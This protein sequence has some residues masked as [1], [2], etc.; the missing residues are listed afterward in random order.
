VFSLDPA[1]PDVESVLMR[2]GHG[3]VKFLCRPDAMP[4]LRTV[5]AISE[6]MPEIGRQFY[7]TGPAKGAATLRG[8]LECQ[9]AA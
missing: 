7:A 5:I 1:D 2:L 6:R 4:P 8:Y 9:V 3:Y